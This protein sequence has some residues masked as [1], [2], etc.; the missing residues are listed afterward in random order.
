MGLYVSLI[1]SLVGGVCP[2][3]KRELR[4]GSISDLEDAFKAHG[5]KVAAFLLE[6]IQGEAGIN[7]PKEGYLTAVRQ[8]CTKYNV[9]ESAVEKLIRDC[10]FSLSQTRSRLGSVARARCWP[11]IMKMS[12][13]IYSS[14]EKR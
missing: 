9:G 1:I 13:L 7:V 12:S 10:R 3:S 2:V 11:L 8:L 4:H 5:D 6:P 14:L